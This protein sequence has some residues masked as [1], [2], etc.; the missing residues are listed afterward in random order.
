MIAEPDRNSPQERQKYKTKPGKL[1]H[2]IIL[3]NT[4]KTNPQK[5]MQRKGTQKTTR[6]KTNLILIA[7]PDR[8][9]PQERQKY[10]TKPGKVLYDII[11]LKTLKH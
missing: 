4:P 1:L 2:D 5:G 7:K 6:N 11:L 3:P 8:N 9:S 10:K